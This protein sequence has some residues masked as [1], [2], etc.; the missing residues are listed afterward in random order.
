MPFLAPDFWAWFWAI[1]TIGAAATVALSLVV[2]TVSPPQIHW[3]HH[4]TK[5]RTA[6]AGRWHHQAHPGGHRPASA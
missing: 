3:R 4:P 6:T 1:I 5:R 2:A